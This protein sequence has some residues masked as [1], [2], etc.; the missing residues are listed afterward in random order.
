MFTDRMKR[1]WFAPVT[2]VHDLFRVRER[3]G[4][5]TSRARRPFRSCP[6]LLEFLES[7]NLPAKIVPSSLGSWQDSGHGG[8]GFF[9]RTNETKAGPFSISEAHTMTIDP[10]Q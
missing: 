8:G 2:T 4:S 7:R 10:D 9:Y 1:W 5:A 6:L 3:K